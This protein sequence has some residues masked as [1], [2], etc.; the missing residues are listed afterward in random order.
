MDQKHHRSFGATIQE[1]VG[2]L[3][4]MANKVLNIYYLW[5][6]KFKNLKRRR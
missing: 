1:E 6:K 5:S 4:D 2:A 3:A